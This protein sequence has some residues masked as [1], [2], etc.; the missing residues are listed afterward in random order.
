MEKISWM[1][2][3]YPNIK[4]SHRTFVLIIGLFSL[5]GSV[6]FIF[7]YSK[8]IIEYI[9]LKSPIIYKDYRSIFNGLIFG[10]AGI[11]ILRARKIGWYLIVFEL[12]LALFMSSYSVWESYDIIN[13]TLV[14]A[15]EIESE[16][17]RLEFTIIRIAL[18]LILLVVMNL[19]FTTDIFKS[20]VRNRLMIMTL[21][22]LIFC[23]EFMIVVLVL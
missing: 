14:S 4:R 6:Y 20:T 13:D 2:R 11:Q 17:S 1:K 16:N 3:F 12:W 19:K 21:G 5:I 7:M 9:E 10:F 18:L 22:F 15:L 23:L 8:D